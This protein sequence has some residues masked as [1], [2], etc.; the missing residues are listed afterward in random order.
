M[1][2]TATADERPTLSTAI[3]EQLRGLIIEGD[4][5][6]GSRLNE[7]ALCDRLGVS[8]TPLREAFRVLAA[9]GLVELTPNR[10]AQVVA[11]SETDLRDSFELMGSLEALAAELACERIT[12]EELIEIKALTFQMLACHARR[13]LPSYY[14]LNRAIHDRINRAARNTVL[15]QTYAK[16]NL[17]IQ[18]LRLRS[19]FD[20]GKWAKSARDHERIAALLEARDGV[21]L[22]A[23]MREHLRAKGETVLEARRRE[24]AS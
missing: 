12:A 6:P 20:E 3:S 24:A 2:Q 14:Q 19:N 18:S 10:G 9:E 23:L 4:L 1:T 21:A 11:L 13:D 16:L 5:A 8:R 15:T 22:A 7:R 17:R